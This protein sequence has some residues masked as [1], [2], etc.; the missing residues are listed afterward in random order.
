MYV[1]YDEN[2]PIIYND[3]IYTNKKGRLKKNDEKCR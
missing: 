1:F 3:E 2:R